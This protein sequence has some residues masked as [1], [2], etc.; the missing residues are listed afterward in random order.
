VKVVGGIKAVLS[1]LTLLTMVIGNARLF[2]YDVGVFLLLALCLV[3]SLLVRFRLSP[4]MAI[5]LMVSLLSSIFVAYLA[6]TKS[7]D[8]HAAYFLWPI[9]VFLALYLLIVCNGFDEPSWAKRFWQ[10]LL[11]G[12]LLLAIIYGTKEYERL[13]FVFGPNM[14][15]RFAAASIGVS[16]LAF[17]SGKMRSAFGVLLGLWVV[18]E[19]GSR[20]GIV[21]VVAVGLVF[22]FVSGNRKH[23]VSLLIVSFIALNFIEF[24]VTE[25][26]SIELLRGQTGVGEGIRAEFW[27]FAVKHF[28]PALGH[29]YSDFSMF[30]TYSFAYP[31]NVIVELYFFFGLVGFLIAIAFV[32]GMAVLIRELVRGEPCPV[33]FVFAIVFAAGAC[34]SGDLSDNYLIVSVSLYSLIVSRSRKRHLIELRSLVGSPMREAIPPSLRQT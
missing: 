7:F 23:L 1:F 30:G 13:S 15:Y 22:L 3:A 10:I 28:P 34:F 14:L 16:I 33:I 18:L 4:H 2:G 9:K 8:Y 31:H 27:L 12:F 32:L 25:F 5:V 6:Y 17:S 26:R 11:F 20:G 24:G 29:T 21:A 19:T